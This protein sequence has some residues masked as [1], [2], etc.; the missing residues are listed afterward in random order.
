MIRKMPQVREYMTPSPHTIG[1]KTSLATVQKLMSEYR[2]RHLPVE[3]DGRIIGIVSER[4]V[5]TA[6]AS[7]DV[8]V[9]IAED[10]MIPEP[11]AVSADT[12]LDAV[13]SEMAEDK[14]G[15]ALVEDDTGRLV[16]IFTTVDACRALRQVLETFYPG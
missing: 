16:G 10:I 12:R 8:D 9:L 15:S 4:G 1:G 3:N 5:R 14:Y 2:V 11:F 6:L 13:A 7:G